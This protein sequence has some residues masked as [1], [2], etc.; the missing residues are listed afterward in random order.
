MTDHS[1]DSSFIVEARERLEAELL[2]LDNAPADHAVQQS[3]L[4]S[5]RA[6]R[7]SAAGA[8]RENITRLARALEELLN[9]YLQEERK[10]SA[11]ARAILGEAR[12]R[13]G[14]LLDHPDIHADEEDPVQDILE[15]IEKRVRREAERNG[16]P[17]DDTD[18]FTD[19]FR[20]LFEIF[21]DEA[22]SFEERIDV[23]AALTE[24]DDYD[25]SG[26]DDAALP[27]NMPARDDA[28]GSPSA[29]VPEGRAPAPEPGP[30]AG[31]S[32]NLAALR[33]EIRS[34]EPDPELQQIFLRQVRENTTLL[35]TL[36]EN[37]N[38][39]ADRS[40]TVNE[41]SDLIARLHTSSNYMGYDRMTEFCGQ[42][43]AELEMAGMDLLDEG[44]VSLDFMNSYLDM[45]ADLFPE[46]VSSAA[47]QSGEEPVD[48]RQESP[49]DAAADAPAVAGQEHAPLQD[50]EEPEPSL[51]QELFRS[52]DETVDD[53]FTED[54]KIIAAFT[55]EEPPAQ[56]FSPEPDRDADAP[57]TDVG[58]EP[59]A[60]FPRQSFSLTTLKQAKA[61]VR[62]SSRH[63]RPPIDPD[64]LKS[65]IEAEEYDE[66]LFQIFIE[67]LQENLSLLCSLTVE[68]SES[69]EKTGLIKRCSDLLTALHSSANYMGYEGLT[70]FYGQWIA[71]LEMADMQLSMDGP[72]SFDFMDR[73]I[74]TVAGIFPQ[75]KDTPAEMPPDFTVPAAREEGA[76]SGVEPVASF[77]DAGEAIEAGSGDITAA[78]RESDE[79]ETAEATP[80]HPEDAPADSSRRRTELFQRLSSALESL[81]KISSGPPREKGDEIFEPPLKKESGEDELFNRLSSALDTDAAIQPREDAAVFTPEGDPRLFDRLDTALD[82]KIG[83]GKKGG[84]SI[85][86]VINEILAGGGLDIPG[87]QPYRHGHGEADLEEIA[88]TVGAD[89]RMILGDRRRGPED[90]RLAD[91]LQDPAAQR[92]IRVDTDKIDTLMNHVEELIVSRSSI[93]QLQN[94]MEAMQE[95][96]RETAR[97]NPAELRPLR[98]YAR[99]L[100]EADRALGRISGEIQEDLLH[101]KM[102]PASSLFNRYPKLVS[103]LAGQAR[104]KVRFTI[105]GEDTEMDKFILEE[106]SMP[107]LHILRTCIEHDVELPEER[108]TAGKEKTANLRLEAGAQ[109]NT[110]LVEV[111]SDGRGVGRDEVANTLVTDTMTKLNAT[112]DIR[113][114]HGTGTLVDIRIPLAVSVIKTMAVNAGSRIITIPLTSIVELIRVRNSDITRSD[115]G[116]DLVEYRD[117]SLP[118]FSLAE[119]FDTGESG[120]QDPSAYVLV[121]RDSDMRAGLMIDA[122]MRPGE[123][124][125]KPLA[126][127]LKK[128]SG[129][130]GA[131][132]REDGSI[133]LILDIPALFDI[134]KSRGDNMHQRALEYALKG[135]THA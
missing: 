44:P 130:S 5:I 4:G 114:R 30:A 19:E 48:E 105:S 13:I 50:E 70:E 60:G 33:E 63:E 32:L 52:L 96:L 116:L 117:S 6:I 104:K 111:S 8:G 40:V 112:L 97:L 102:L 109:S 31:G 34:V 56:Q 25:D 62:K 125:V 14:E 59:A 131:T 65:E 55:D 133:S 121:V 53:S 127:Y 3:V 67:Q 134:L 106:L 107:L 28:S 93:S 41:C 73:H 85:D 99:R 49:T 126:D 91:P 10:V 87:P 18:E 45:L 124:V 57:E 37:F 83:A 9:P 51:F 66:E 115:D 80:S 36:T 122:F 54:E 128:E 1:A 42:W 132:I 26:T 89:R 74:R 69:A 61:Q 75:V 2:K 46:T 47:E 77:S 108:K 16:K 12:D 39:A 95:Y 79:G 58:G 29:A 110:V 101:V 92:S 119:I 90:R 88:R 20:D 86:D 22:D 7:E 15:R 78:T 81:S 38:D 100:G 129:F 71:E 84:R 24:E 27:E 64:S 11:D 118:L 94:E 23:I 120:K 43:I 21:D 68:L 35:R 72:V 113:S 103:E 98:D 76:P 123:T 17:V 82:E 135:L